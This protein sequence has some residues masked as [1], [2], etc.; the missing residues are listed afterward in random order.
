MTLTPLGKKELERAG[1]ERTK[2]LADMLSSLPP[3]HLEIAADIAPIIE[4]LA[5]S[6]TERMLA[7]RS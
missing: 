2:H 6:Y 7:K 1:D 4:Q 3:E 5:E